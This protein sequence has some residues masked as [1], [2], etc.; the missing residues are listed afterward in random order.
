MNYQTNNLFLYNQFIIKKENIKP[1]IAIPVLRKNKSLTLLYR[2]KDNIRNIKNIKNN[3][4]SNSLFEKINISK[5]LNENSIK[6]NDN[7]VKILKRRN[8]NIQD[9][10]K[11]QL[12][13]SSF[14]KKDNIIYRNKIPEIN[15]YRSSM[16]LFTNE[17]I[18]DALMKKKTN[19]LSFANFSH[20][21]K[22]S[23]R[24]KGIIIKQNLYLSE[25][26]KSNSAKELMTQINKISPKFRLMK[27]QKTISNFFK[28]NIL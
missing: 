14:Q 6:I 28:K 25:R 19:K 10:D 11:L 24:E 17:L 26:K 1:V 13:L 16:N 18:K 4:N 3:S 12:T 23:K 15:L 8:S 7:I 27:I 22:V 2:N 21:P 5:N 9:K 20:L